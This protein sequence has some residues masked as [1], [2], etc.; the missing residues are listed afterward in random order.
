MTKIR[1]SIYCKSLNTHYV[2]IF[3]LAEKN[4]WTF[5]VKTKEVVQP[6]LYPMTLHRVFGIPKGIHIDASFHD[7]RNRVAYFFKGECFH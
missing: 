2:S 1:C 4:M 5:N 6:G 7:E 3:I